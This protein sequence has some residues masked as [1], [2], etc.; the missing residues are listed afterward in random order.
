MLIYSPLQLRTLHSE[1]KKLEIQKCRPAWS[2]LTCTSHT[3]S[4]AAC[5]PGP[6]ATR[7]QLSAERRLWWLILC[8]Y[9]AVPQCPDTWASII[10]WGC[11]WIRLT[12]KSVGSEQSWLPSTIW[13]ASPYQCKA[14]TEQKPVLSQRILQ[15]P[16]LLQL[17]PDVQHQPS[18]GP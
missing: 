3:A 12:F 7:I 11:F 16:Q 2:Q 1:Q 6:T 9:L 15:Q 5:S 4:R 17:K 8:F 13:W 10:L 14:W 18:L